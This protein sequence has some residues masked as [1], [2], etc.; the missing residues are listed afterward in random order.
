VIFQV[1]VKCYGERPGKKLGSPRRPCEWSAWVIL[2][3]EGHDDAMQKAKP[4]AEGRCPT[5]MLIQRIESR[6]SRTLVLPIIT[7]HPL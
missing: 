4:I 5:S 6:E 2:D 7:E 1:R 3:A